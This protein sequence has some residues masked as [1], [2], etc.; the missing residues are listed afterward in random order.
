MDNT[1]INPLVN[2]NTNYSN[3]STTDNDNE[4]NQPDNIPSSSILNNIKGML[5][6]RVNDKDINKYIIALNEESNVI[7]LAIWTLFIG[8]LYI[9]IIYLFSFMF[10]PIDSITAESTMFSTLIFSPESSISI[11]NKFIK[12]KMESFS[13]VSENSTIQNIMSFLETQFNK[14]QNMIQYWFHRVLLF[15]YINKNTITSKYNSVNTIV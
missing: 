2:N 14:I 3:L 13:N 8:I 11:F 1:T 15:F 5:G 12:T 7:S 6:Y 10:V 4:D 9:I